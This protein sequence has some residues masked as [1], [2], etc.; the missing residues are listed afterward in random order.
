MKYELKMCSA[1]NDDPSGRLCRRRRKCA[2]PAW[3]CATA[4]ALP[5]STFLASSACQLWRFRGLGLDAPDG[6][7]PPVW[8]GDRAERQGNMLSAG[9]TL[10]A[11][12]V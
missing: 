5:P 8:R 10:I 12:V 2:R 3:L 6:G 7:Q 11:L 4:Q 9:M 1:R